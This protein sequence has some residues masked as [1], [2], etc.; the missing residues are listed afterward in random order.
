[1]LRGGQCVPIGSVHLRRRPVRSVFE[2]AIQPLMVTSLG[3]SGSTWILQMLASHPQIIANSAFPYE[4]KMA[5]YWLH[6]LKV[7]SEPANRHQSTGDLFETDPWVVGANPYGDALRLKDPVL[8]EWLGRDYVEQQAALCQSN[9]EEW[10]QLLASRQ[11]EP[12]PGGRNANARANPDS[13]LF[14]TEKFVPSPLQEVA[15]E[16]Y[17]R[18]KEVLLVRDFRDMAASILAFDKKRGYAGFG[19][20]EGASDESY[21]RMLG[22]AARDLTDAWRHRKDRAHLVRY[23]DLVFRPREV[24]TDLL[25]YLEL[26]SSK[27][28]VDELIVVAPGAWGGPGADANTR[29]HRTSSSA[30]ASVGRW[31]HDL[32]ESLHAACHET[33]RNLLGELGYPE[34]GYVPKERRVRS[35]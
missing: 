27:T 31:R 7:L 3:R 26:D 12:A 10:Y 13:P 17:P 11:G 30:A 25:D 6:V 9:I 16:L 14:F 1:V 29:R 20:Q 19:R 34:N 4:H 23:E 21:I 2:P 5:G 28:A 24:L 15:W 33:F 32:N 35:R 22:P 8:L 18:A